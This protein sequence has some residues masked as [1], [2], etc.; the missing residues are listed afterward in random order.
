EEHADRHE[1]LPT[2]F[3]WLP[4]SAVWPCSSR[5]SMGRVVETAYP[6]PVGPAVSVPPAEVARSRIPIRPWPVPPASRSAGVRGVELVTTRST[7]VSFQSRVTWTVLPGACLV[8][9]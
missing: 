7:V 4:N 5:P 1:E 2:G 3:G 9:L 8:A 6:S